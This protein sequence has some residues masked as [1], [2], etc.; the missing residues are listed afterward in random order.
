MINVLCLVEWG[1]LEYKLGFWQ[2]RGQT[3][4]ENN[5]ILTQSV[6]NFQI[7]VFW[8]NNIIKLIECFQVMFIDIYPK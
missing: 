7:P 8:E 4:Y 5:T 3:V 2:F 1:K 6:F